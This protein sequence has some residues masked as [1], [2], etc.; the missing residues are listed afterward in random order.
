MFFTL[1]YFEMSLRLYATNG[2]S[3][4]KII[5]TFQD[6]EMQRFI[7][8]ENFLHYQSFSEP[9]KSFV[10]II[11]K[12]IHAKFSDVNL[13]LVEKWLLAIHYYP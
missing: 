8:K 6:F 7:M 13:L 5:S 4:C 2:S 3:Q 1:T 10:K 9:K 11:G 12:I